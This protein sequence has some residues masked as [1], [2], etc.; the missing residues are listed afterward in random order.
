[1]ILSDKEIKRYLQEGKLKLEP[2]VE[3]KNI[4]AAWIDLKLGNEFRIFKVI[5]TPYIDLKVPVDGYTEVIKISDDE[6]FIL[7]P[8]EFV[9]CCT[10]EYIKI[11]ED[12]MGVIDGRS[13]LGRLGIVVHATAG[14]IDPGWEGVFTLEVTNVGKMPVSLYPGMKIC[15][16]V[17]HKLSSPAEKPY[18]KRED[19]KYYQQTKIEE[20]KIFK[21]F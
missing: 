16:L 6:P 8:G 12:L 9:L 17:L 2:Q 5:S 11:P 13:S 18:Y 4:Q 10:R 3:E 15:K 19:A 21:E 20:S 7:H 1:M 14:G